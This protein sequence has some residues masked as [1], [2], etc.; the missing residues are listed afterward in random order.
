VDYEDDTALRSHGCLKAAYDCAD[1]HSER[2]AIIDGFD[3]ERVFV[4]RLTGRPLAALA[5]IALVLGLG[6]TAQVAA[7]SPVVLF[8]PGGCRAPDGGSLQSCIKSA[9]DG[10]LI[11]IRTNDIPDPIRIRNKS[12][13]LEPA[14]G[15]R[16]VI[17]GTMTIEAKTGSRTVTVNGIKARNGIVVNLTGGAGHRV[18]LNHDTIKAKGSGQGALRVFN[19]ARSTVSV[20]GSRISSPTAWAVFYTSQSFAG[21]TATL[22]LVGNRITGGYQ[23]AAGVLISH[24]GRGDLIAT[25]DNN[26]I[27]GIHCGASCGFKPLGGVFIAA[28]NNGSTI[29]NVVGDTIDD[30]SPQPAIG[31]TDTQTAGGRM[32]VN[33]F[34][35]V[36]TRTPM[37]VGIDSS[38]ASDASSL[39]FA[40]GYNDYHDVLH[41]SRLEGRSLGSGNLFVDPQYLDEYGGNLRVSPS[42]PI[43]DAGVVCSPGG[44]ADPDA[45]G[46]HRLAGTSVDMGAYEVNAR[47]PTG[48]V[49]VGTPKDDTLKG[50]S[51]ADIICGMASADALTGGRGPDYIDG[52]TGDDTL[53]GSRGA[54][55]LFGG[56]GDDTLCG[57]DGK[58]GNDLLDGGSGVDSYSADQGDTIVNVEQKATC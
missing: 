35:S 47:R 58:R 26:A 49:L 25:I 20:T 17:G 51:G 22:D 34:N 46:N 30:V 39:T 42:S 33:L 48:V 15:F 6:L 13:S 43:I 16:P 5:A 18:T 7:A 53:T 19:T 10:D 12:V 52:G 23:T 1:T 44:I 9:R 45:D 24:S 38:G 37:A 11:R 50:T 31:M 2:L 21:R 3:L 27:S 54:D 4:I 55:R 56:P 32:T 36:I 57:H 14:A 28:T 29:T 40:A 8:F 41:P